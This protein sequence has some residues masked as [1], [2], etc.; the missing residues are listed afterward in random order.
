MFRNAVFGGTP[1]CAVWHADHRLS[2]W[3]DPSQLLNPNSRLCES[4]LYRNTQQG[5]S[6]PPSAF[7]NIANC[8]EIP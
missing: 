8:P 2:G 1:A 5:V 6:C 4:R 7:R 3:K